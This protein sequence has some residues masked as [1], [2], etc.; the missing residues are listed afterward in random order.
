MLQCPKMTE[1]KMLCFIQSKQN[2]SR[3]F[4]GSE[5]KGPTRSSES[6]SACSEPALHFHQGLGSRK[7]SSDIKAAHSQ[8]PIFPGILPNFLFPQGSSRVATAPI[9]EII[10]E[11][12]LNL[13]QTSVLS[14][15]VWGINWKSNTQQGPSIPAERLQASFSQGSELIFLLNK[16]FLKTKEESVFSDKIVL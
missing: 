12:I 9:R 4:T 13:D 3:P 10:K 8:L 6:N 16:C 15:L 1:C 11:W 14:R 2:Q 5:W 7:C